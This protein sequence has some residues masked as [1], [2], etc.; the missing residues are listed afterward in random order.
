MVQSLSHSATKLM[1][2]RVDVA[3][4]VELLLADTQAKSYSRVVVPWH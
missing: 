4:Q 2:N 3:E 1:Q